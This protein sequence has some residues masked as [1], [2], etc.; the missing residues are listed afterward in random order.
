LLGDDAGAVQD[1]E[2]PGGRV[3]TQ[4]HLRPFAVDARQLV[5]AL[6]DR[7]LRLVEYGACLGKLLMLFVEERKLGPD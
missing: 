1:L 5:H 2:S 3:M 4:L 6:E 7:P